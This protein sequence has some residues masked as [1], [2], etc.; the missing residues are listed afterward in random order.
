[1][2]KFNHKNSGNPRN[3]KKEPSHHPEFNNGGKNMDPFYM[4]TLQD[5]YNPKEKPTKKVE[6]PSY[7][8]SNSVFQRT[9]GLNISN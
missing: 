6:L 3:K 2:Q 1:M 8:E 9:P 4:V 7:D 5:N